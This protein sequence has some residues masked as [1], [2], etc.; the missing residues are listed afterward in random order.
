MWPK[1]IQL[2]C[3]I[4]CSLGLSLKMIFRK[5]NQ[6]AEDTK[7]RRNCYAKLLMSLKKNYRLSVNILFICP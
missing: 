5:R 1:A 2:K 3:L 7:T 4:D 6:I